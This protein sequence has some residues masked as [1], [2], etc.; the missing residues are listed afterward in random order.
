M[1]PPNEINAEIIAIAIATVAGAPHA[2]GVVAG[3]GV[4][5]V[6]ANEAFL[7]GITREIATGASAA[8]LDALPAVLIR[9]QKPKYGSRMGPGAP[10]RVAPCAA[11]NPAP[12]FCRGHA[13]IRRQ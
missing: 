1:A 11:H 7:R 13:Q 3:A 2:A 8:A 9:W 4:V 6:S 5:G 12:A 10:V